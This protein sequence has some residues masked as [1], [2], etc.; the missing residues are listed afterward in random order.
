MRRSLAAALLFQFLGCASGAASSAS[1]PAPAPKAAEPAEVSESSQ[2][3]ASEQTASASSTADVAAAPAE[4]TALPDTV[5]GSDIPRAALLLVLEQGVGR[6]LQKVSIEPHLERG[7]F[8]GWRIVELFPHGSELS[9]G[10]LLPGDTLVR[11]NGQSVERP[12]QVKNVWDSLATESQLVLQVIRAGKASEVR[13]R[14]VQS[15]TSVAGGS[16]AA[17]GAAR[18]GPALPR[19]VSRPASGPVP[20]GR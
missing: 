16:G 3:S 15:S 17:G 10:V 6:F 7:R 5:D 9:R 19:S 12:E 18:P 20:R 8:V 4:P 14:I 1:R 2:A 13:H 11:V